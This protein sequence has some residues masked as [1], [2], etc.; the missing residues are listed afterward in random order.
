VPADGALRRGVTAISRH[1]PRP[2]RPDTPEQG[3]DDGSPCEPPTVC[4]PDALPAWA[5]LAGSLTYSE[6]ETTSTFPSQPRWAQLVD[7]QEVD[8]AGDTGVETFSFRPAVARDCVNYADESQCMAAQQAEE[9]SNRL[10]KPVRPCGPPGHDEAYQGH[11]PAKQQADTGLDRSRGSLVAVGDSAQSFDFGVASSSSLAVSVAEAG[12]AVALGDGKVEAV[13][14]ALDVKDEGPPASGEHRNSFL[15][16]HAPVERRPCSHLEFAH[17]GD[18][19]TVSDHARGALHVRTPAVPSKS[20]SGDQ[21]AVHACPGGAG[22]KSSIPA[23]REPAPVLAIGRDALSAASSHQATTASAKPTDPSRKPDCDAHA[24]SLCWM[25]ATQAPPPVLDIVPSD[26]YGVAPSPKPQPQQH[27]QPTVTAN[28]AA[29]PDIARGGSYF[30]AQANADDAESKVRDV[31]AE[32][33]KAPDAPDLGVDGLRQCKGSYAAAMEATRKRADKEAHERARLAAELS[34]RRAQVSAREAKENKAKT[35]AEMRSAPRRPG[36]CVPKKAAPPMVQHSLAQ[37]H[38]PVVAANIYAA[39]APVPYPAGQPVAKPARKGVVNQALDASFEVSDCGDSDD[40]QELPDDWEAQIAAPRPSV[41]KHMQ[42]APGPRPAS[43]NFA[44]SPLAAAL[45]QLVGLPGMHA[46]NAMPMAPPSAGPTPGMLGPA[47]ADAALE[48][49]TAE[50]D[51][52]LKSLS[53]LDPKM[54]RKSLKSAGMDLWSHEGYLQLSNSAEQGKLLKSLA[55]LDMQLQALRGTPANDGVA[56]VPTAPVRGACHG[57]PV[58]Q[59]GARQPPSAA[60]AGPAQR[61]PAEQK[62]G[63]QA[64]TKIMVD[65]GYQAKSTAKR[66]TSATKGGAPL[67]SAP[68]RPRQVHGHP[69]QVSRVP[70]A[71][72]PAMPW[73]Q[74]QPVHGHHG[75]PAAGAAVQGARWNMPAPAAHYPPGYPGYQMPGVQGPGWAWPGYYCPPPPTGGHGLAP[76][77]PPGSAFGGPPPGM[78]MMYQMPPFQGQRFEPASGQQAAHR[79]LPAEARVGPKPGGGQHAPA[80]KSAAPGPHGVINCNDALLGVLFS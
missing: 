13:N 36:S 66:G 38:A 16:G 53:R 71:A 6:Q 78:P 50:E 29:A 79:P 58:K 25:P 34:K 28:A 39:P 62:R 30:G 42:R 37:Q 75:H 1:R 14:P 31:H 73:G 7:S 67:P 54:L 11:L 40:G 45:M 63:R 72:P 56:S 18:T 48:R 9:G 26:L 20:I 5:R 27:P 70:S 15:S 57:P 10:G 46:P 44:R 65:K 23:Q 76:G 12:T 74:Q 2:Q 35:K 64:G 47:M 49:L 17:N 32:A 55:R 4:N 19:T 43:S 21:P 77:Q 24:P 68:G 41:P 52:L 69:Q 80:A 22:T 60:S 59:H 3:S 8:T 61:K 33:R 51:A